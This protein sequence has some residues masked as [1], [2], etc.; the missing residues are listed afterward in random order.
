MTSAKPPDSFPHTMDTMK[1]LLGAT[2][3]LLLGA[4]A[5]SWQ[6][7]KQGEKNTPPEE[8]ARIQREIA[9]M[10]LEHERLKLEVER[11]NLRTGAT[12]VQITPPAPAPVVDQDALET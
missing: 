7:L 11:Q 8:V 4:L 3:A 10:K 12:T 9:E 5:M 1:L 6:G 2:V